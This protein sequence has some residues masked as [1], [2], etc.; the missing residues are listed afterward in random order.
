MRA[1]ETQASAKHTVHAA[2]SVLHNN[3]FLVIFFL[4][5]DSLQEGVGAGSGPG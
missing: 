1:Q 4:K 3:F 5:Q 2:L